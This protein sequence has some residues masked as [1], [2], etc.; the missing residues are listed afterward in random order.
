MFNDTVLISGVIVGLALGS[1]GYVLFRFAWRPARNYRRIKKQI[2]AIIVPDLQNDW[3]AAKR[4]R[5]RRLAAELHT[6]TTEALP[7]WFILAL[8]RRGERPEE[9]VRQ[10]QHLVNCRDAP[11]LSRRRQAVGQSLG[12]AVNDANDKA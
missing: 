11:A 1:F 7:H 2:A 12:L 9:T 8:N 4:D 3:N 10:L 6:L 5:L